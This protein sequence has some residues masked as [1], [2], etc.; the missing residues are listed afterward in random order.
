MYYQIAIGYYFSNNTIHLIQKYKIDK[1][2]F[3]S[4]HIIFLF[5]FFL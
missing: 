4:I 2:N 1:Y 5:N 3:D